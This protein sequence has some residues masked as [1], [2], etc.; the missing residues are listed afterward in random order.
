MTVYCR[1]FPSF[2]RFHL[3]YFGIITA[4]PKITAEGRRAERVR[5]SFQASLFFIQLAK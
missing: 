3:R 5:S 1:V 2:S 4:I